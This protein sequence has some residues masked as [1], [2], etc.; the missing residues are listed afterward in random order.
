MIGKKDTLCIFEQYRNVLK[1]QVDDNKINAIKNAIKTSALAP[2]VKSGL[3]ALLSDPEVAAKWKGGDADTVNEPDTEF[4]RE[5]S[6]AKYSDADQD[7]ANSGDPNFAN[8]MRA[9][10]KAQ[11]ATYPE[12]N[13]EEPSKGKY[14]YKTGC[15][16]NETE[17]ECEARKEKQRIAKNSFASL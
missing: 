6:K 8:E 17:Q 7:V 4:G 2:E 3:L 1:E 16:E 15:F 5:L 12:Q 11:N 14:N 10:Q 9:A 13:D